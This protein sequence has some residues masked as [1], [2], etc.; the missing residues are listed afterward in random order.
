LC[1]DPHNTFESNLKDISDKY[2]SE[3]FSTDHAEQNYDFNNNRIS[4]TKI[5]TITGPYPDFSI[6]ANRVKKEPENLTRQST[7]RAGG[8][9]GEGWWTCASA[10]PPA[11]PAAG[12]RSSP[13]PTGPLSPAHSLYKNDNNC[14][15]VDNK[16]NIFPLHSA[17]IRK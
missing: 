2:L 16:N 13:H 12:G 14:T 8:T 11:P 3:I 17:L 5:L 4:P 9:C 7:E 15:N 1:E 6:N 10:P